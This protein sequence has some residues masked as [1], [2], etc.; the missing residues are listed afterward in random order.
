MQPPMRAEANGL[1]DEFRPTAAAERR[2][3]VTFINIEELDQ[4]LKRTLF[5]TASRPKAAS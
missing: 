4:I 1:S 2:S 3:K 5:T